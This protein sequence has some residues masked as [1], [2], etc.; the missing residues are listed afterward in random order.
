MPPTMLSTT[1][2]PSS[3]ALAAAWARSA[4]SLAGRR[5]LGGARSPRRCRVSLMAA[6]CSVRLEPCSLTV[7]RIWVA[8]APTR[9]PPLNSVER[10]RRF[11]TISLRWPLSS[12]SSGARRCG[13]GW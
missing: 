9:G 12:R 7:A 13:P 1:S 6:D 10:W 8:A 2:V 11:A 5:L 3:L 4:T